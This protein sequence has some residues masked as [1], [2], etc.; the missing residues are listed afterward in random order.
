MRTQAKNCFEA[1][2][3]P[4]RRN[5]RTQAENCFEALPPPNVV[6]S[7][8]TLHFDVRRIGLEALPRSQVTRLLPMRKTATGWK[9]DEKT[10]NLHCLWAPTGFNPVLMPIFHFWVYQLV[11]SLI[12]L[13]EFCEKYECDHLLCFKRGYTF[14][15]LTKLG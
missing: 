1:L 2:P 8:S 3:P 11:G 9:G 13:S 6:N 15:F 7:L 4:N 12:L 10:Q 5:M 14:S